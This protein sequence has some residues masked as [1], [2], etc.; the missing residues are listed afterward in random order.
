MANVIV[1]FNNQD[2]HLACQDGE[3]E[4]LA[5]L[6]DYVNDKAGQIAK[7][8]GSVSDV[9]LLLMTAIL[10]ADELDEARDGK[11][12]ALKGAHDK[13]EHE[14]DHME[15]TLAHSIKRIEDITRQ[16]EAEG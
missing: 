12:M 11:P 7:A 15:K 6:A 13:A 14:A 3:G 1:T 8:M 9:R 16:V 10:L 5:K 4:R 2:Y